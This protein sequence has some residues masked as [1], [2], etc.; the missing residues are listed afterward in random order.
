MTTHCEKCWRTHT[1]HISPRLLKQPHCTDDNCP[2]HQTH[3]TEEGWKERFGDLF[4]TLSVS[5][6]NADQLGYDLVHRTKEVKAFIA[7][8]IQKAQVEVLDEMM[9]ECDETENEEGRKLV[10]RFRARIT[11]KKSE[12]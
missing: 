6:K 3:T 9:K 2:C 10:R 11:N 4:P 7:S 5:T 8:E 12:V 1:T